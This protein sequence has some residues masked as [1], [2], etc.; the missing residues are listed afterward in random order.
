MDSKMIGDKLLIGR[1]EWLELP[2][3]NIPAI[4]A[5]IDTGAKTSSLHAINIKPKRIGGEAYVLFDVQ[6]LQGN[7]ELIIHCKAP[8]IDRRAVMSSNGS[9]ENRY[10]IQAQIALAK[11]TW[12]IEITLSDRDPLR[13]R[14]LLGR[15]AL[16]GRVLVDPGKNCHQHKI[17]HKALAKLY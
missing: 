5:K 10:V 9:K 14:M 17:N 12:D 1:A 8:V 13:Y 7:D 6:P 15:E 2:A 16:K 11:M 4:K 3:L